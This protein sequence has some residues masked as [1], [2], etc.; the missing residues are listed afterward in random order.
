MGLFAPLTNLRRIIVPESA[1]QSGGVA[2]ADIL[3]ATF[4]ANA[5]F[6]VTRL[7]AVIYSAQTTI[8]ASTLTGPTVRLIFGPTGGTINTN[9][10]P[11]FV[12]TSTV[13]AVND[14]DA[15]SGQ[16]PHRIITDTSAFSLVVRCTT[17]GTRYTNFSCG[18]IVE[19]FVP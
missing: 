16:G 13:N 18:F 2:A 12:I 9:A 6:L 1:V 19:G 11:S 7:T 3:V 5:R 14:T 8:G 15:T 10:F 4:P 17:P